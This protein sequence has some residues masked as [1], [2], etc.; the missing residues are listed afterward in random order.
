MFDSTADC[1]QHIEHVIVSSCKLISIHQT[2]LSS[3]HEHLSLKCSSM[4]LIVSV[5]FTFSCEQ[6]V[7]PDYL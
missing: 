5:L 4:E 3:I 2:V 1:P 7:G 6:A